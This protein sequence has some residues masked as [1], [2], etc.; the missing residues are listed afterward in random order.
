MLKLCVLLILTLTSLNCDKMTKVRSEFHGIDSEEKLTSFLSAF[1]NVNCIE[2][3][4]YIASAIM[5]KSRY[6]FITKKMKYFNNGKEKLERFIIENPNDIES[7][8]VRLLVQTEI[9]SFLNY[10]D[11][12]SQDSLFIETHISNANLPIEYKELILENIRK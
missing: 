12:I 4:P 7:K 6:A 3:A 9:P 8:Y 11:N 2:A 1:E 5:T 10:S